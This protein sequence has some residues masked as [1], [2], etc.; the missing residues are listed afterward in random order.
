[1]R[2]I[3]GTIQE[4]NTPDRGM[5]TASTTTKTILAAPNAAFSTG[6]QT[7]ALSPVNT[8]SWTMVTLTATAAMQN[9]S[10]MSGARRRSKAGP[11]QS[12]VARKATARTATTA[13]VRT[14]AH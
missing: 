11:H 6:T 7:A 9:H 2:T 14:Y 12:S 8:L 4:K 3:M 5:D 13:D 10:P 1:M